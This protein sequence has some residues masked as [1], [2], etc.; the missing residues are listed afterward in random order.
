MKQ[1]RIHELWVTASDE[2]Y[3]VATEYQL[4]YNEFMFKCF[5]EG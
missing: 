5:G 4:S 2:I 1:L 3:M